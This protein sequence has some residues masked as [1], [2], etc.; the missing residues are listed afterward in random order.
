MHRPGG[1]DTFTAMI[2]TLTAADLDRVLAINQA[3]VPEVGSVDID[4]MQFL[5]EESEIALVAE[6]GSGSTA[7]PAEIAGFCLVLGQGSA[8]E[9]VNYAW[10]MERFGDAL[11]LDRVAFDAAFQGQGLGT[12]LYAEVDR[13]IDARR[14]EG[15][16]INRLT[17]EV[18][19]DPPNEQ[20]LAFHARRGFTEAGRQMTPYGIE[21][22][23][24]QKRY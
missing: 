9:S 19:V 7:E 20:S 1:G 16:A 13:L 6:R 3:N 8:Y 21:V 14:A 24:Q 2:R 17:L 10:C 23:Y 4:R 12:A 15:V 22:A 18:N 11:Y 5:V